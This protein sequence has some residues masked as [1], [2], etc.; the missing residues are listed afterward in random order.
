MGF[1][2][3][4]C[5]I[6]WDLDDGCRSPDE[7]LLAAR[8]LAAVGYSDVAPTPHV[9]AR[10]GGGDAGISRERLE[11]ARALL[12]S[13]GVAIVLHPGGENV[14]DDDF[15]ARAGSDAARGLGSGGRYVLVEVPFQ[16]QVPALPDLVA[17]LRVKGVTPILAHPERCLEFERPGRAAE[18]VRLGAALQLNM[19]ALTGRHGRHSRKLAERF[20]DEGLYAVAGTDLHAAE[21]AEEWIGEALLTLA[22]RV[23]DAGLRRLCDENP[24]RALAGEDLS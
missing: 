9:Q 1:V 7:T 6:L 22:D 13:E 18:A 16:A 8:S 14:L 20:L 19:G 24:R 11:L 3:L 17:L 15:L 21:G 23:G 12:V 4:H 5:H 10:Y 2:D